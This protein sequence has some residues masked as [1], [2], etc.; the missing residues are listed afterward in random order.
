MA[1]LEKRLSAAYE[2]ALKMALPKQREKLQAAQEAWLKFRDVDCDYY[3]LGGGTIA[4]IEGGICML[5]LTEARAKELERA[6]EP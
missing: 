3:E 6:V 1:E 2:K 5:D 4:R